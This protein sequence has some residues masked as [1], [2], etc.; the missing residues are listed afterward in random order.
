MKGELSRLLGYTLSRI[1]MAES[2][3]WEWTGPFASGT[4]FIATVVNG[5]KHTHAV[6]S[7][8][9]EAVSRS[10]H[11]SVFA[12]PTCGNEKCVNPEHMEIV[13]QGQ[14]N[15]AAQKRDWP[16]S[17][18]VPVVPPDDIAC[19]KRLYES[20]TPQTAIAEMFDVHQSTI[21]RIV[22]TKTEETQ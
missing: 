20:G 6:R 7:L 1:E 8:T 21:S 12:R 9:C 18:F 5:K 3:C 22:R 17:A 19:I 11:R 13:R 15:A 16:G 10:S 4:P 2:G 14:K